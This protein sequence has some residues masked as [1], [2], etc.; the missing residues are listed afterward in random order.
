MVA[1]LHSD[2]TRLDRLQAGALH[3]RPALDRLFDA[4]E[5]GRL[6]QIRLLA[7]LP[8]PSF[9]A[10]AVG[11]FL[12]MSENLAEH[13]LEHLLDRR[14]LEVVGHDSGRRPLYGF[15]PLTRLAARELRRGAGPR[16]MVE[17]A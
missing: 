13:V 16:S 17:G 4:I 9:T 11:R 10:D 3:I 5:E 8:T 15:P 1:H 7:D 12:G 6:T 2:A 14:L